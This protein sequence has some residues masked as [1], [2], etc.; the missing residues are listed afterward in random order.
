M[1]K[2]IE[3]T[4]YAIDELEGAARERARDWTRERCLEV[5]W[6][7]S[8]IE[9]FSTICEIA[10]VELARDGTG[11]GEG[12]PQVYFGGFFTQGGGACFE[13]CWGDAPDAPAR[14]RGH[15]PRDEVLHDIVDSLDAAQRA[16]DGTL[17]ADVRL[18][19]GG[20]QTHE[21]MMAFELERADGEAPAP[22]TEDTAVEAL[23]ALA[24]WLYRRLGEEV[25]E[26]TSDEAI[27]DYARA[28]DWTFTADGEPAPA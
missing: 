5:D 1:P 16:N 24:R 8:V 18:R 7:D 20:S 9:D 12:P 26:L 27:D 2:T 10:G 25:E 3:V 14:I 15:A 23:R 4:V 19:G 22:G 13:G 28:N 6:H 11:D 21:H 17:R